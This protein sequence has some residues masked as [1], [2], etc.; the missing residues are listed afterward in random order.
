MRYDHFDPPGNV[1]DLTGDLEAKQPWIPRMP[2]D[3]GVGIASVR[4]F[5]ERNGRTRRFDQTRNLAP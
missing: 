5:L 2:H 1:D 3:F 4:E